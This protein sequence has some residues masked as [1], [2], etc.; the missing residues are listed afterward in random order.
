[1]SKV[2]IM[3]LGG[4][5]EDGKNMYVFEI[6]E[7]IFIVDCGIKYPNASELLGIEYIIPDFHYILENKDRVRAI[8]ITHGHD[9]VMAALPYLLQEADID[10]YATALTA[11]ILER[12]F[13][14]HDL[15]RKVK[16]IK[17]NS[18]FTVAGHRIRSFSVTQSIADGIG[19]AFDTPEGAIVYSSEFITDYD[20]ID[21]AF[22]MDI[23]SLAALH[24]QNVLALMSESVGAARQGFTSPRHRI[25]S[26]VEPYFGNK[27]RRIVITLYKQNLFRIIEVLELARKY[28]RNVYFS[29]PDHIRILKDVEELGYYKVPAGLLLDSRN[30]S[31]ERRDVVVIVSG[32]GNEVF[33][34]MNRIAL[35][36]DPLITL[37]RNDQ[38]IIA[39]PIVPG[40]EKA[41]AAMEDDLYIAGIPVAKIGARQVLSMHASIEDLKMMLNVL[42]PRYYIPVK[43]SYT[44]LIANADVAVQSGLTPD[45]IIILDNGQ[46]AQLENGKL[47]S[48]HESI[49]LND[50]LISGRDKLDIGGMVIKDRETLSTDGVII[51]GVVLDFANKQLIGGP[52]VQSRGVIYLKDADYILEEVG[53]L[54]ITTIEE[55]V[56]EGRYDNMKARAEA[57]EKISRYVL[58]QTGKRPM[59]MPAIIEINTEG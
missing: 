13:S 47:V 29:D 46:F 54:L 59:V 8:F 20:M 33:S 17:R 45:R 36:E 37:S 31:N 39:S 55:M 2:R 40:T 38:V 43:G 7:D 16:V 30:F 18:V 49:T 48:T 52:D 15:R 35:N 6:G 51:L 34:Y 27:E 42:Q 14:A 53:N 3:A 50:T 56:A 12:E 22:A 9:D 41:G 44:S 4:L 57:K 32:S 25:S 19:L 10:V 24:T 28:K 21:E 26:L 1:M 5:C 11:R 23:D 58:K